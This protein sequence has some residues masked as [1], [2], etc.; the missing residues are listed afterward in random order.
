MHVNELAG[1]IDHGASA[2]FYNRSEWASTEQGEREIGAISPIQ[3][4]EQNQ[5]STN[6]WWAV[7]IEY[8][9]RQ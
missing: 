9:N 8:I 6:V 5:L 3:W 1:R 2:Q 7:V 4:C